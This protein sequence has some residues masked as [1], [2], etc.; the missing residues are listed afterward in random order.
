MALHSKWSSGDLIFY[1]GTQ[2]IFTI[3]DNDEGLEIAEDGEGVDV[4]FYGDTTGAYLH[5]D[6]SADLLDFNNIKITYSTPEALS[7]TGDAQTLTA[8]SNRTQFLTSTGAFNLFVPASSGAGVAGIQ[9]NVFNSTGGACSIYEASTGGT[10][11]VAL[12][13][14]EGAVLASNA[15]EWRCIIGST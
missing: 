1:D 7:S 3:K 13:A 9:F 4:K 14:G 15:T 8:A 11:L 5:F 6:E 12:G 10:L 2:T